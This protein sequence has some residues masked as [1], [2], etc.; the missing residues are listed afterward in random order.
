LE[1]NS[2]LLYFEMMF[3]LRFK[4]LNKSFMDQILYPR[5]VNEQKIM[6]NWPSSWRYKNFSFKMR[7]KASAVVRG[8]K[9]V[10]TERK[11]RKFSYDWH[12][13]CIVNL[14]FLHPHCWI[15]L[16]KTKLLFSHSQSALWIQQNH[17]DLMNISRDYVGIFQVWS[18]FSLVENVEKINLILNNSI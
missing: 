13:Y 15:I 2:D 8:T 5:N 7:G 17:P 3:W 6:I 14:T 11:E 1:F 4:T 16:W 9:C 12:F 10:G 18:V